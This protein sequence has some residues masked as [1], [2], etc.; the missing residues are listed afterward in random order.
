MKIELKRYS[1][2][3]VDNK[4]KGLLQCSD[5]GESNTDKSF[6]RPDISSSR[7]LTGASIGSNRTGLYDFDDGVDTGDVIQTI[8]RDKSLDRTEIDA[9]SERLQAVI[10]M[11]KEID[12]DEVAK[13]IKEMNAKEIDSYIKTISESDAISG[14]NKKSESE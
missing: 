9:L 2:S 13:K 12:K 5:F 4:N 3:F 7:A 1:N 6:Y 10:D 14:K 8:L 11:K